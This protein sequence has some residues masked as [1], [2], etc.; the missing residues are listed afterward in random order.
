MLTLML[1]TISLQLKISTKHRNS[2]CC[3]YCKH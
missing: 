2:D 3:H 1:D